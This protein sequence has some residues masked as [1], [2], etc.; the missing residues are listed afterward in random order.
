MTDL[1][2]WRGE[3][4]RQLRRVRS[5][6]GAAVMEFLQE[7]GLHGTFHAKELHDH[8]GAGVAPASADRVLRSLRA[9]GLVDYVVVNRAASS[10]RI[11]GLRS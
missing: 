11:T 3:Q 6:I 8:V 2:E 1:F 4:P 10:Y 5:N 7:R 9:D